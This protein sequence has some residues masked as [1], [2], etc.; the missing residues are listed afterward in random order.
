MLDNADISKELAKNLDATNNYLTQFES[1]TMG[2]FINGQRV[3]AK[4]E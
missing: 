3:E 4:S 1:G 2:H